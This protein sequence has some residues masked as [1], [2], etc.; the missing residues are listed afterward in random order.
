MCLGT[1]AAVAALFDDDGVPMARLNDGTA[2]C[3]LFLPDA[4]VGD[5]VLIHS[6]Y[7]IERLDPA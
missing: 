6:G 7:V 5:H 4:T 1:R 2:A 3:L